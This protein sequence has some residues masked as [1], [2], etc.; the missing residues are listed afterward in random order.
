MSSHRAKDE[1]LSLKV[2]VDAVSR[3]Y[4][5]S[6]HLHCEYSKNFMLCQNGC[7]C[8]LLCDSLLQSNG[9]VSIVFVKMYQPPGIA[10]SKVQSD[11]SMPYQSLL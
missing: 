9:K 4:Q 5:F 2:L 3:Y 10:D 7:F 8:V 11:K 6:D 1:G